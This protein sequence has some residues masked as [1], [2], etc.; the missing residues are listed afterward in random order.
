VGVIG[1]I[2]LLTGLM[3]R[4]PLYLPCKLNTHKS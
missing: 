1:F 2:L 4:C 3:S